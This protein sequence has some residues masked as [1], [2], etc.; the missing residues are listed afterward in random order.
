[1]NVLLASMATIERFAID[2]MRCAPSIPMCVYPR[3]D[4][5]SCSRVDSTGTI[6]ACSAT[7]VVA[8]SNKYALFTSGDECVNDAEPM[9]AEWGYEFQV[10]T[11][12]K[13]PTSPCVHLTMPSYPTS[14]T[15]RADAATR[16]RKYFECRTADV[17]NRTGSTKAAELTCHYYYTALAA[18]L[19]STSAV[20][21]E[22]GENG[23]SINA[24]YAFTRGAARQFQVPWMVD[25]SAWMAG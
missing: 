8:A 16:M 3:S 14:P 4:V 21:C 18:L 10:F 6:S 13:F 17:Y 20:A 12:E 23:N 5:D 1:M 24:H 2:E 11:P 7:H 19:N 15:D 25:F 9:I 22:V